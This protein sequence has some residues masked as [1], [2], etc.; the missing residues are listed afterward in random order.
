LYD[1]LFRIDNAVGP[2]PDE[3]INLLAVVG[4]RQNEPRSIA[5]AALLQ[6]TKTLSNIQRPHDISYSIYQQATLKGEP[7]ELAVAFADL[8]RKL[9]LCGPGS[10]LNP[11]HALDH[12]FFPMIDACYHTPTN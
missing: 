1:H 2:F 7:L 10:R 12:P 11:E 8:I 3:L 4:N 5:V 6:K 9:L